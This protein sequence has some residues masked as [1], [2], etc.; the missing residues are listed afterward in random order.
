MPQDPRTP[1]QLDDNG[2]PIYNALDDNGNPVDTDDK[3]NILSRAWDAISEPL[4]HKASDFAK[5]VSNYITDPNRKIVPDY[6]GD[7]QLRGFI[8]GS[9]EGLGGILD[10]LTSPIS[11]ATFGTAGMEGMAGANGLSR[12]STAAKLIR[13][14][15]SGAVAAHGATRLANPDMK[16]SDKLLA[17]PEIAGGLAGMGDLP[18]RKG[19]DEVSNIG[20]DPQ[21]NYKLERV[22][23]DPAIRKIKESSL[24]KTI[25]ER[26][27]YITRVLHD[28]GIG[29]SGLSEE[30]KPSRIPSVGNN[31]YITY[32]DQNGYPVATA[33]LISDSNG[34]WMVEDF[35]ADKSKGLLYGRA[36]KSVGE[37]L[38]ESG[39]ILSS[40]TVTEDAINLM[41]KGG[42]LDTS[43]TP[44]PKPKVKLNS[45]GTYSPINEPLVRLDSQ[46]NKLPGVLDRLST[47]IKQVKPLPELQ[48]GIYSAERS[49]RVGSAES[50]ETPGEAG[51][52]Q[53]LGRLK[54]EHTKLAT[55]PLKLEQSDVDALFDHINNARLPFY[56]RI[57]ASTGLAKIMQGKVP[58]ESEIRLMERVFG[59]GITDEM[60]KA[61]PKINKKGTLISEAVNLPK[62][63]MA[64]FD[65]S[66]GGRQGLGLIHTKSWWTNMWKNSVKA[67]GSENA[68]NGIMENILDRPNFTR[69]IDEKTG[70]ELPS[71]AEKAGLAITDLEHGL[72]NREE[73]FASSIAEK[74]PG[75][76]QSERAY[77]AAANTIR[78]DNFDALI[79]SAKRIYESAKETGKARRGF[80]PEKF[81]PEEVEALNPE[82]NTALAKSIA[83]YV[84]TASGRGSLGSLERYATGLNNLFFS[85]RMIAS[86]LKMMNPMTYVNADPFIRKQYLKS[87][88]GLISAWGTFAGLA[89]ASGAEV[90]TDMNSSD[91]GKI[92]IGNT[93]FDPAGGFQQYLVLFHRLAT[94]KMTTG[95][96]KSEDLG[97][98]YGK[99]SAGDIITQFVRNKLSPVASYGSDAFFANRNR[100]F[101]VTDR[102]V[103]LFTP[104]ILQDMSDI[105]QSDPDML[106]LLGLP[107]SAAGMGV[108]TYDQRGK[109]TSLIP[110]VSGPMITSSP[111]RTATDLVGLSD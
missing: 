24:N 8:G 18:V 90:N 32:R 45:D 46:G 83:D 103:R 70:K 58:Q 11:L 89:K 25:P 69:T 59:K 40:S 42:I 64:S 101:D 43:T 92:K 76:R 48:A 6:V 100:P 111:F 73:Q 47:A 110:G 77:T 35:V 107:L 44:A 9:I 98:G 71:L 30:V 13:K 34:N 84:N 78:A 28:A 109:D 19:I 62:S 51:F 1:S 27:D 108:Q 56:Q 72:S 22:N 37:K 74:V 55:E 21:T 3:G 91:F 87:M 88:L 106:K 60:R 16:F 96:E 5:N 86:R 53:R 94:G 17:I 104:M 65:I 52:Y 15:A 49:E 10:D 105:L 68:Y 7:A 82:T 75:V 80:F 79:E 31:R 36:V 97:S 61:L 99:P 95:S 33:R 2:N 23:L 38:K 102:T 29:P 39:I 57:N 4:T 12:L 66:F 81:S 67:L 26:K 85:P 50:V 14:G 93:R 54:G 20:I 41:R 63:L